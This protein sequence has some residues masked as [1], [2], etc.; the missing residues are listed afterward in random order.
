VNVS[1]PTCSIDGCDRPSLARGWCSTHYHR[2]RTTG[3]TEIANARS[4]WYRGQPC[5]I[6]GCEKPAAKRGW[7]GTHYK[8][9]RLTGDPGPAAL[10]KQ[11]RRRVV[12]GRKQC[13]MCLLWLPLAGFN[14]HPRGTGGVGSTCRSCRAALATEWRQANPDYSAAW[15]AL[16]QDKVQAQAEFRRALRAGRKSEHVSPEAVFKRDG[17][18]CLLCFELLAMDKPWPHPLSPSIDHV[19]PLSLGGDHL[20][21]NLQ[22]AHL[23]CNIRKGARAS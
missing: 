23:R 3:S 7:C 19:V 5:S 15:R 8:R 20:Y 9:W 11:R 6:D 1:K 14:A 10:I 22:A 4:S 17:F 12:D 16:N 18:T 13:S 2:W 21:S